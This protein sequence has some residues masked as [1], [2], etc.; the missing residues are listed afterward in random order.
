[1][2]VP[3][4]RTTC[5]P[6]M[7]GQFSL[8][9]RRFHLRMDVR[10]AFCL[11]QSACNPS[12]SLVLPPLAFPFR[13]LIEIYPCWQPFLEIYFQIPDLLPTYEIPPVISQAHLFELDII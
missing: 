3:K 2:L 13:A 4:N 10:V 11:W 1:M 8:G 7:I 9:P 5:L 6:I 12:D